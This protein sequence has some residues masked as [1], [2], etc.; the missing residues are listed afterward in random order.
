MT[1]RIAYVEILP[2]ENGKTAIWFDIPDQETTYRMLIK[3][4]KC[5]ALSK[6]PYTHS[7][8]NEARVV[9]HDYTA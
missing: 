7:S 2:I 6:H 1:G 8:P 5:I 4:G 9:L 3:D